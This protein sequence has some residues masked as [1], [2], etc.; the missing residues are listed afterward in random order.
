M[1]Y[2]GASS[3]IF[4]LVSLLCI[5]YCFK[6][7][8]CVS[9]P[10]HVETT[11]NNEQKA[12]RDTKQECY[13]L[14]ERIYEEIDDTN[15]VGILHSHTCTAKMRTH[16]KTSFS[17]DAPNFN[18]CF[19]NNSI[20]EKSLNAVPI[21]ILPKSKDN[22]ISCLFRPSTDE[23]SSSS[24]STEDFNRDRASYLHPYNTLSSKTSYS[25]AYEE[26]KNVDLN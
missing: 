5:L 14:N 10:K 6:K 23:D 22:Q 9:K 1:L 4:V 3:G 12:A 11:Q 25:H 21:V 16:E 8:I 20:R 15:L 26:A 24:E 2:S 18:L 13:E 19:K 7:R 17:E